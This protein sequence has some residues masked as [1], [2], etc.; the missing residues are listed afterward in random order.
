KLDGVAF[1]FREYEAGVC[2]FRSCGDALPEA[3]LAGC[4]EADAILLGAMGLPDV[5]QAD[6]T[7]LTPQIDLREKLDLYAG[8]RPIRTYHTAHSPLRTERAA[9]IDFV[10]YRENTEGLFFGRKL[11]RVG[12]PDEARDT[13][14]ISRAASER[15]FRAAFRH[16]ERRRKHVT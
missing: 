3:T 4:R 13:M 2:A 8:V 9:G 15:L 14:R 11:G 1:E 16:A 5:R 7:E 6:G 10:I 12:G